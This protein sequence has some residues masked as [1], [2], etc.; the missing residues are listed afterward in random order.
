MSEQSSQSRPRFN[1]SKWALDHQSLV[2]FLMLAAVL[3]GIL[4]YQKLSRNEDPPFTIKTMVVGARW[5]G[6]SAADTVNLL[7]DKLEKK[8]SET[9]HLDYTQSYTRPG[10]SVIMV[11]LRDDT[12][13]SEVEGIWYTVRKKIADISSTLPE[14]VEG[15]AFDDE[16]GD[17]Y[18]SIYAFRAEGFSQRELRDRVEAIRSEILSLPDIGKVN[19]LGAQD[20]QIVIEFSQSKLAS[21]D[22]DPSNAI[23][24]IRAQNSVNPIGTVQTSEEKISVRVT[25]AFASEDSLK[26]ITLKLGSRY[27]RL[28]SIATIS[29]TITDP[30]AASVRVNGKEVIGLAVSMAKDGNL[31][32]FGEALKDRMHTLASKLPYG[33]EMIQVA[34]QST[35]VR[36]A[37]NGFMKVL[38]EAIIIVLAVSFISLGARAGLVITASIPLVLALTFLGMELTGVGLQ[39]ISL[40][41]LIIALGLLVDDAMITVESMVSCLEKGRSRLVAATH[42][43]ETTA[44]PMLTGTLVMIAGFIPVGFAASSAGEYTFSLFMV[45]LIALSSSWIVAVLFSPILGTWILPRSLAHTHKKTGIIM[46]TYRKILGWNL[47][48]RWLTILFA[49]AAFALSLAGLGQLKQQFFPASDRPELLVGLTLPQNAS[50]AATDIRARELETILRTDRDIDHFITY[51]GSGSIRFY[52]PMDLQLD[53]DNVSETVVVAKSVEKREA[54]RRKIEAVLNERFSDLVTRVSPLELGPPVGWPLKFR[55]SGPDYQQ[56]RALSAKVAAIIGQNPDTR[57]VNLTAGEPQK[58]VTIKV[59]QIEARA[60][61]MSSESIA[62]EIAAVFSGSKVTTV[63]DKDKLVDVMVKGVEADRNSVSTIGNLELRTGDGNYVPLRQVASVA[64][65]MEDPIIWRQQGKPM[66][67]VQADVQKNALAATV[68]MQADAQLNAL[69]SEL[70]M[71]YSIIAGGITEESEKGNSSIYAVI[72]VMLFAIAILLMVQMQSFSRM[73][74]A[75]FMAPFGLIGVVAAMWPTGTPMGF[76]AQLGVI[77]LSGM[78]IRNAV[79]LI[80]EIDQNVAFGQSPKDAI[81]AAS[82]HRARPIVLTACAAI[83]GMIPIAAEIFWGPMAFAIIGGLAVATMLTL[84]LLPCAMSLLLNAEHKARSKTDPDGKAEVQP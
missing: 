23:E 41:A 51:V 11:N 84:T 25:G 70:P 45:I 22:I 20:E 33:I 83:L 55:V 34:D 77:A 74:L 27:F 31:L 56:V 24:A 58:S 68:A 4:S 78:I 43:Y 37:V 52:L 2:I 36:D 29:R 71:G 9:P 39:R 42:A 62:S 5:P 13:P 75:V 46:A 3:S 8:L 49:I 35:V 57:D 63:R 61:G 38:V 17:T 14:G 59:N 44:F 79:I 81:I 60:L 16:F 1:L 82:I 50:R 19:I 6:A 40:G 76:V 28:D 65:G 48:H 10:Q 66:I 53:N 7:T 26:D 73:A 12:P 80:Q 47:Q 32:T 21:L 30:P 15:P 69:R 64:Y 72:P 67:I 18:G 54:V